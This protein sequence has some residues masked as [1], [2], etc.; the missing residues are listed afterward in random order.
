MIAHSDS[1]EMTFREFFE[2][3]RRDKKPRIRENTWRTKEAIVDSK[4]MPYLG[5]LL[6]S[7]IS[8]VS[9]IQWQNELMKMKDDKGQSYSPTY[10]RTIHAQLS[11]ILNHA[12][13]FYNLKN[14]VAREVGLVGEKEAN[15]MLFWTREEYEAFVEAIK[16]KP[17]SFYAFE[18]L[19]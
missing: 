13:K 1:V 17:K 6:L 18:I 4:I 19:Y 2:L 3:Y 7:E 14:N 11:S 8:K 10:L 15:E 12:C 16:D 9:I 5:D